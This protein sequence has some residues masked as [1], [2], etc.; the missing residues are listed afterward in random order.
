VS[1]TEQV[2]VLTSSV[3]DDLLAMGR[4]KERYVATA[5]Q[6]GMRMSWK[7]LESTSKA[8][9]D[10]TCALLVEGANLETTRLPRCFIKGTDSPTRANAHHLAKRRSCARSR[11][12][13]Y[14]RLA[15]KLRFD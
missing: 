3:A 9:C 5:R 13:N 4:E 7:S 6:R 2:L 11:H 1:G 15:V 10:E 8:V 14:G 12:I